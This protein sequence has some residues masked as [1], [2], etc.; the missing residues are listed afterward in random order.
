MATQSSSNQRRQ[1]VLG[2]LK[3]MGE[4]STR[5]IGQKLNENNNGISQTLGSMARRGLVVMVSDPRK[6][7]GGY[8]LWQL[9]AAGRKAASTSSVLF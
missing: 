7:R 9:T 1:A 6:V 5:Q 4:A 3:E 8:A 2:A